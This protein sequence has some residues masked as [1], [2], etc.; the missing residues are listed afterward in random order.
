M[1]FINKLGDFVIAG[2]MFAGAVA[3]VKF[4]LIM[5]SN[6]IGIDGIGQ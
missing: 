6:V 4:G 2:M 5:L 3:L 1:G